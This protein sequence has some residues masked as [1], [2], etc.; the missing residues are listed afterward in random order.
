MPLHGTC[1]C[2]KDPVTS[3]AE[4][5]DWHLNGCSDCGETVTFKVERDGSKP[6]RPGKDK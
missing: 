2:G 5:L 4:G 3:G 6:T 1:K